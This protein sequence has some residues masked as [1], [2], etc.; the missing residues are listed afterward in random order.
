MDDASF[1]L[2]TVAAFSKST[3]MA[4]FSA[5]TIAFVRYYVNYW[6]PFTDQTSNALSQ[7]SGALYNQKHRKAIFKQKYKVLETGQRILDG[8][9][10]YVVIQ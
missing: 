2:G 1:I 7:A 5:G 4:V 8:G 3:P 9:V 10:I 6:R